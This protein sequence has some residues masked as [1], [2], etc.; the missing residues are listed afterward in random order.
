MQIQ[1]ATQ[2]LT[3][4]ENDIKNLRLKLKNEIMI[5]TQTRINKEIKQIQKNDFRSLKYYK[6]IKQ[7]VR[8][9]SPIEANFVIDENKQKNHKQTP[10]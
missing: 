1:N 2:S 9:R 5:D 8:K 3:N 4:C 10:C 7:Q 6:K